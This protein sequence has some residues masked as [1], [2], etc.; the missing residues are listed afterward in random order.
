M[1]AA[2]TV[3]PQW[4]EHA[5]CRGADAAIFYPTTEDEIRKAR[6]F[7]ATCPVRECCLEHALLHRERDGIWGGM[8]GRE[9]RRVLRQRYGGV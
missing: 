7:C 9:R 4:R 5:R 3:F 1:S 6:A 2:V 8:T